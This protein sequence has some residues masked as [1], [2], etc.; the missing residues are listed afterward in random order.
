MIRAVSSFFFDLEYK[1]YTF[2]LFGRTVPFVD[3]EEIIKDDKGTLRKV[4]CMYMLYHEF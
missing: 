3:E 4:Q 1:I 2:P